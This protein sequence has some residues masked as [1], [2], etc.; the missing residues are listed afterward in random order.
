MIYKVTKHEAHYKAV[1]FILRHLNV[2]KN[3]TFAYF[4]YHK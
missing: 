1:S 2:P 3:L 4:K